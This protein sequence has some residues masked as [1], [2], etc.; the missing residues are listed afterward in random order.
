VLEVRLKNDKRR[1][2]VKLKIEKL[3]DLHEVYLNRHINFKYEDDRLRVF[4]NDFN[5]DN[6][7]S[8]EKVIEAFPNYLDYLYPNHMTIKEAID[9]IFAKQSDVLKVTYTKDIREDKSEWFT[10]TK[11]KAKESG[12]YMTICEIETKYYSDELGLVIR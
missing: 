7:Y 8:L 10:V 1:I 4:Y 6:Y 12:G 5:I 11:K 3:S 9:F 2:L